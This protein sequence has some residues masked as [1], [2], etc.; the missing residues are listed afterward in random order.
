MDPMRGPIDVRAT[1]TL[2]RDDDADFTIVILQGTR[3]QCF[4]ATADGGLLVTWEAVVV[5]A[6]KGPG[7]TGPEA[8]I[9][10]GYDERSVEPRDVAVDR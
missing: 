10:R 9:L 6:A 5:S 8:G 2:V 7:A 3:G 1:R 4:G